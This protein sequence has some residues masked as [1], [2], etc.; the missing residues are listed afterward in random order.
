[1][2]TPHRIELFR[3]ETTQSYDPLTDTYIETKGESVIVPC[4][5][6]FISQAKVFQEYGSRQDKI[7]I[8]RFMQE[9]KSFSK[10]HFVDHNNPANTGYYEPLDA[11]DAPIKGAVRL[12]EVQ[13]G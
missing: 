9:Q 12:K 6:N 4:L 5:V 10:A 2:K 7:M 1:M 3:G 13:N 11:I 8:C